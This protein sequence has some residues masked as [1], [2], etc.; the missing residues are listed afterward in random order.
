METGESFLEQ[1]RDWFNRIQNILED[2]NVY[3]HS[4]FYKKT[5]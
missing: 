3:V 2:E 5:D 4:V 1:E